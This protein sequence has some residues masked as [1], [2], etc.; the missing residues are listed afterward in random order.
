MKQKVYHFI[1][2]YSPKY[3]IVLNSDDDITYGRYTDILWTQVDCLRN[4]MF[5]KLYDQPF[6][7][8]YWEHEQDTIKQK[9]PRNILEWSNEE[10]RLS[11]RMKEAGNRS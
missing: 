1:K 3:V 9:Y 2:K 6:D 7:H 5:L 10:Q 11:K 8:W 4:E